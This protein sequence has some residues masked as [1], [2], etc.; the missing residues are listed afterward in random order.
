ME[1]LQR[2]ITSPITVLAVVFMFL[3]SLLIV[4]VEVALAAGMYGEPIQDVAQF[5]ALILVI[6]FILYGIIKYIT[7]G[8]GQ[9]VTI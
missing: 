8:I 3:H 1:S 5:C 9:E 2:I 4:T 7:H 6:A